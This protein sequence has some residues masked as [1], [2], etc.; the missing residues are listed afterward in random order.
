M[1][2]Y[3]EKKRYEK[4]RVLYLKKHDRFMRN[5]HDIVYMDETGFA[6]GTNRSHAYGLKGARVYGDVDS[7]KRPRTSLIGGYRDGKL[8]A[9]VLF[10]G[11]CNTAVFN[12]WLKD[13][14]LPELKRG[15]VIVMDNATFHKSIETRQIIKKAG[16]FALFLP[17][18]SP[19]LNPIEKLWANIKRAWKYEPNGSLENIL[20]SSNYIW[21]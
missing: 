1:E 16:C 7:A 4:W 3:K 15:S 9:P 19:H 17:P 13:H 12:A 10:D 18:Y 6:P 21:N 2:R 5:G 20:T 14:L 8:I 11:T